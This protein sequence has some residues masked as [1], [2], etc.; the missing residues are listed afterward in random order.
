MLGVCGAAGTR[1]SVCVFGGRGQ[2]LEKD[3]SLGLPDTAGMEN[4]PVPTLLPLKNGPSWSACPG[5][6]SPLSPRSCG[7]SP[8]RRLAACND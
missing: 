1:E 5:L 3:P 6:C 2:C 4:A 7:G 8:P